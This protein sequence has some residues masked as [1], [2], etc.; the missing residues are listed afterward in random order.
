MPPPPLYWPRPNSTAH[1]QELFPPHSYSA[2]GHL[3]S[4]LQAA[5]ISELELGCIL[6]VS[7][8]FRSVDL[9]A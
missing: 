6:R 9:T 8:T 7:L 1:T 3:D 5:L 2:Q 4:V